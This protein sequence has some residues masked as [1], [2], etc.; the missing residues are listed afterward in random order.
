MRDLSGFGVYRAAVLFGAGTASFGLVDQINGNSCEFVL[1]RFCC[2][3]IFPLKFGR[4]HF[5]SP[6]ILVCCMCEAILSLFAV[7]G[8]NLHSFTA[9][10]FRC[11]FISTKRT[12]RLLKTSVSIF[13][14]TRTRC[15]VSLAPSDREGQSKLKEK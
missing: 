9:L 3:F 4:F 11:R 5:R 8:L 10:L 14:R 6:I 15:F 2:L 7:I 13:V 12:M 1:G